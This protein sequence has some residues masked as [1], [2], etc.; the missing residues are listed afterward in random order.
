MPSHYEDLCRHL[1]ADELSEWNFIYSCIEKNYSREVSLRV[2]PLRSDALCADFEHR[3]DLAA[4]L[5]DLGLQIAATL[6]RE[7]G[8]AVTTEFQDFLAKL[9]D[10]E[11]AEAIEHL[12]DKL[13]HLD[14]SNNEADGA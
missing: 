8:V 10:R 14:C 6:E 2:N 5:R 7:K 12:Q 3:F 4:L 9:R 1:N 11:R 13:L